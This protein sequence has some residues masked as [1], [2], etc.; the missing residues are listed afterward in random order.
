MFWIYRKFDSVI[1][2]GPWME[3]L[4]PPYDPAV[5]AVVDL[6][7][8]VHVNPRTNRITDDGTNWRLATPEEIA[9]F[10]AEARRGSLRERSRTPD[11]I[12]D[13]LLLLEATLPPGQWDHLTDTERIAAAEIRADRWIDLRLLLG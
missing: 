5:F 7:D 9:A 3:A 1:R 6:F 11:R 13:I 12:A 10:D 8:S 4:I 2:S